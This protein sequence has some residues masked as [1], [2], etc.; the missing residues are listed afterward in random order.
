MTPLVARVVL[1][2]LLAAG[3]DAEPPSTPLARDGDAL[4]A[5]V[6]SPR[7]SSRVRAAA[8]DLAGMLERISGA[9]FRVREGSGEDGIAL[10]VADDF[11]ALAL[12]AALDAE[13]PAR[14]EQY[15]LRSHPGGVYAVGATELAVEHAAW[16]LLHRLGHRQ[17]LPGEAWEVVPRATDLRVA[18]DVK[19]R[20]DYLTRQI[21][22]GFGGWDFNAPAHRAWMARNRAT[23]GFALN[24]GHAYGG[25]IRRYQAVFD[26]HPEY[27]GLVG[28]ERRSTKLCVS[29]PDVRALAVRYAREFFAKDPGA[30]SVSID[31]SDGG[32][33]CECDACRRL[34]SPSD[35]ALTLANEI[36]RVLEADHPGKYVAMYAYHEHAAPP[37]IEAR[38]RVIVS[39]ATAFLKGV[40]VDAV[41]DGWRARGVRQLGVRE[42][43][44]VTTWDRDL[45]GR[46]RGSNLEYL[47]RT[48]PGFHAKGARFLTAESSDG[49]GPNGLG[50]YLAARMTWDV[51]EASRLEAL[52]ADFLEKA[53]GPA[54]DPMD[55][56]YALLDGT[57]APLLSSDLVGRMYRHLREARGLAAADPAIR[58]RLDHLVLY[59]R[60]VELFRA[61]S[62]AQG[63]ARQG[64]FEQLI[65]HAYRI[66]R[67]MMVHSKALYRD[68]PQ[69]DRTVTVP[70]DARWDVPED[71]NPWKRS[72]PWTPDELERLVAG[73]IARNPVA[74]FEPIGFTDRLVPAGALGLTGAALA[75]TSRSRGDQ[76]YYTWI[77]ETPAILELTVTAGLVARHRGASARV[78]IL[79]GPAP[80]AVDPAGAEEVPA[81]AAEVPGDGTPH[82]VRLRASARGLHRIAVSDGG[83]GTEVR[84]PRGLARTVQVSADRG[85]TAFGP[86]SGYFYV[87]RGTAVVGGYSAA[88]AVVHDADGRPV[89]R[90][91]AGGEHFAIR[92]PRGQDGRLWSLRGC[93]GAVALM[94]VPPFLAA[95]PAEL[96][97]PEPVVGA[98][99]AR[100]GR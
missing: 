82:R 79:S 40:Q 31:P 95:D 62:A 52:R 69:R 8:R 12:A 27:L 28:G 25:I 85:S 63:A 3:V 68:L 29:N 83:S 64:A 67:T 46:S 58:T 33:W 89:R 49:W 2:L 32:G 50:H 100:G 86:R 1:P 81:D 80:G 54:R 30:D 70:P 4:V 39:A 47:R 10:G 60:Y 35:R 94:T 84:F 6:V 15:V 78:R 61:Y 21:W 98:D 42:Y 88:G 36:S 41:I 90:V 18:V 97:L 71:R 59:T 55:R 51:R 96:L 20:P 74:G 56:F 48:I 16:D 5:V 38:P 44:G 26:E 57:R 37:A 45:P 99:H 43:F 93:R 92:V 14:R 22:F 19:E 75:D 53:F 7:A 34:G 65:R 13:P 76:T 77:E 87:P 73:G 91:G 72:A 23:G 9:R 66:S 11:P 24:T 17:L